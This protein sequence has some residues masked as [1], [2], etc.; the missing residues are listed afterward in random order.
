MSEKSKWYSFPLV[1]VVVAAVVD[2]I[3]SQITNKS[4]GN[5]LI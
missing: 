3:K 5:K 2:I 1:V 4:Y